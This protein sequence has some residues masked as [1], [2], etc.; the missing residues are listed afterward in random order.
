LLFKIT[1]FFEVAMANPK[2]K[3]KISEKPT[4]KPGGGG[5]KGQG[6]GK[7]AP[8]KDPVKTG[9]EWQAFTKKSSDF[10]QSAREL[11]EYLELLYGS[12]VSITQYEKFLV[13]YSNMSLE[14]RARHDVGRDGIA[15]AIKYQNAKDARDTERQSFR[16]DIAVAD[17]AG[18]MASL[19]STFAGPDGNAHPRQSEEEEEEFVMEGEG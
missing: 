12:Q 13:A 16:G 8:K 18:T 14:E 1:L 9:Y 10:V 15:L 19:L 4:G 6:T 3:Q 11:S 17:V 2:K 5:K 7:P